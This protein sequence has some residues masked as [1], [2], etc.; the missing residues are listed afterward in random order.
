MKDGVFSSGIMLRIGKTEEIKEQYEKGFLRFSC[1][2]NWIMYAK[3]KHDD[4][5]ADRYEAIF[6]HLKKG[7][8]RLLE[9]FNNDP[10]N[11]EWSSWNEEGPDDTI[12]AR[13][14]H[15]C[16]VPTVCFYSIDVE[17]VARYFD[18]PMEKGNWVEVD[19]MPYYESLGINNREEYSILAIH[20]VKALVEELRRE[21][22]KL[23]NDMV[24]IE[25]RHFKPECLSKRKGGCCCQTIRQYRYTTGV[26]TRWN[27]V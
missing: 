24:I 11:M 22:P 25:K 18:L 10:V 14:I 26:V 2:G 3:K 6:A 16:L 5:I 1:P 21:I 23:I 8:P 12:Y 20:S 19:L 4:G 27:W 9:A 15:S 7:D 13:Y 17:D